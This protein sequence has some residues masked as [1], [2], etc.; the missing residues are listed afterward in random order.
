MYAN[1]PEVITVLIKQEESG[2][3]FGV[4]CSMLDME[5][6]ISDSHIILQILQ[7]VYIVNLENIRKLVA[8]P[9]Y[10]FLRENEPLKDRIMLLTLGGS[11]AYGTNIETSDV[12]IRGVALNQRAELLGLSQFEQAEDRKT[13]TVV[14]SFRKM[15]SLLLA[16]NP[17]T[18]EM[19]GC[20]PEQYLV[21]TEAGHLLRNNRKLF[22]SRRAANTFGGYASQKLRCLENYLARN[23]PAQSEREGY[24]LKSMERTAA[25]FQHKFAHMEEGNIRLYTA[26]SSREGFEEEV[27]A[28]INLSHYPAQ[29]LAGVL[30]D[31]SKAINSFDINHR[32]RKKDESHLNKHAMHLIRLLL[33]C[34]DILE[35]EEIITCRE[36][37]LPL[38]MS[39]RRGEY[40]RGDGS[41]RPEFFE[42][43]SDLEKRVEYAKENTSLPAEP[44]RDRVEELVMEINEMA[45][46]S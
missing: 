40:M 10:D 31:L 8:G 25:D 7:E 14:Y 34:L 41:F 3:G 12:D 17:N 6:E 39:I 26:P 32:N 15:A 35:K 11:H 21:L 43:L 23:A 16:C 22:L 42:I 18:I 38:L 45:I 27:F 30:N 24:I 20:K 4:I 9:D 2:L 29:D 19:L 5:W 44:D 37:D 1:A 13:D 46:K 33:T 36:T 28:D